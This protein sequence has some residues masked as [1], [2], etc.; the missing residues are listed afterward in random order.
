MTDNP[1]QSPTEAPPSHKI[2][3]KRLFNRGL[4]IIG[5]GFAIL[6]VVI[7]T[8]VSPTFDSWPGLLAM[9]GSVAAFVVIHA[10]IIIAIVA[11]IWLF[12]TMEKRGPIDLAL[13]VQES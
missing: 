5:G 4:Y 8:D 2:D 10:G 1:Y 7:L 9:A 11:G 12:F 3:W 13:N 6:S